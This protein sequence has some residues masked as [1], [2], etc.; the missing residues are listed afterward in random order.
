MHCDGPPYSC[1]RR[2]LHGSPKRWPKYRT[3]FAYMM[4]MM[5]MMMMMIGNSCCPMQV[6]SCFTRSAII[7]KDLQLPEGKCAIF[8]LTIDCGQ[9][10]NAQ[11]KTLELKFVSQDLGLQG[12]HGLQAAQPCAREDTPAHTHE[13]EWR[14]TKLPSWVVTFFCTRFDHSLTR[15]WA[16]RATSG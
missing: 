12:K 16:S 15:G 11:G 1:K 4:M 13:S 10:Q 9:R 8:L 14:T 3:R 7:G 5:M 2:G 6:Q